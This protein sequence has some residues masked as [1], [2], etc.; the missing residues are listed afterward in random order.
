M[1]PQGILY[2]AGKKV[3]WHDASE[4]GL[5]SPSE[6][7]ICIPFDPGTH[8]RCNSQER[9]LYMSKNFQSFTVNNSKVLETPTCHQ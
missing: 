4:D 2:V 8:L 7:R 6:L 5:A 1:G 9:I 3:N